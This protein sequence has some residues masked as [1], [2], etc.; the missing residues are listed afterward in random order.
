VAVVSVKIRRATRRDVQFG[1]TLSSV[2]V[3]IGLDSV[4]HLWAELQGYVDVLLGRSPSPID[5]PYL[6]LMEVATAY[7]ARAQ[8]MDMRIHA[9]EREGVVHRGS[10]LYK[11]RTGEL[12][13]FIELARKC[14]DLGSRRLT[15]EALLSDARRMDSI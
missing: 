11:F 3:E 12:K 15:Q 5:S 4:E 13:S 9:A 6:A 1:Q 2:E 7:Y 8:E 14:A 10:P